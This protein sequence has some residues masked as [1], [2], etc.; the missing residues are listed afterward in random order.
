MTQKN[1]DDH[2]STTSEEKPNREIPRNSQ[3][4]TSILSAPIRYQEIIGDL[5]HFTDCLAHCVSADFKMSAG[6]ARKIPTIISTSYPIN[7]DHRLNRL[8]P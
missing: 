1:D 3:F 6:I 2:A 8:W 4:S 7:L 5:F